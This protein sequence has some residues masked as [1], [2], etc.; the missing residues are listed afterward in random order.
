MSLFPSPRIRLHEVF[1]RDRAET[2][3]LKVY[4]D[5]L[6]VIP[7]A[8]TFQLVDDAGKDVVATAAA[9]ISGAG[10][11]SYLVPASALPSTKD[12]SD[13]WLITWVATID[14]VDHTFR[15]PAAL[16]RSRLYPVI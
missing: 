16:A 8:A 10:E 15:R 2:T 6:Q 5:G 12:F 4:E 3:T 7:S 1:V 11:L 9:T 14:G 13:G